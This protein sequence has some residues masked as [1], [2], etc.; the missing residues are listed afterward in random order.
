M[1]Y[2][3]CFL[4]TFLLNFLS[5]FSSLSGDN[6]SFEKNQTIHN[7]ENHVTFNDLAIC[8]P[9]A[10]EIKPCFTI[11]KISQV[12]TFSEKDKPLAKDFLE[13][14]SYYKAS[15]LIDL[16]LTVSNIIFPFHYFL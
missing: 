13:F 15:V 5:I 9:I 12:L 3:N 7:V 1:V 4:L 14:L 2:F 10:L 6:I 11:K 16:N 8:S